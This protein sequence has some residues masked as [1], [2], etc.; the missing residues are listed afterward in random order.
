M[1]RCQLTPP[2][3]DF[4]PFV[5]LKQVTTTK[6]NNPDG[7]DGTSHR[8]L[9]EWAS[10]EFLTSLS[11]EV[12]YGPRLL[13]GNQEYNFI[14]LEDFGQHP[15]ILDILRREDHAAAQKGVTA[16]GTFLGKMQA[17]TYGHEAPF[18][19]IQ[20][21]RKVASP[22]SDST[23]DFRDKAER[24][25]DCF[26]TL[27]FQ[28]APDFWQ[29]VQNLEQAIHGPT[30][31]RTFIHANAGPHNFLFL[32]GAVQLLDYEFGTY[33]HGLLD[34]VSARK[35]RFALNDLYKLFCPAPLTRYSLWL[36]F[37]F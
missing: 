16:I 33:H 10:L 27:Q 18:T 28:P 34:V 20:T 31:W 24:F 12:S 14:I 15:T 1:Q 22:L 29:A 7:P 6:F 4:P 3:P 17:A 19:T 30:P 13:A 8:F 32:D 2:L 23:I 36:I 5:I 35:E 37:C 9:N 26:D 21:R 11:G 25:Q